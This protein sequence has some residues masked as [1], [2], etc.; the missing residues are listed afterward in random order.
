MNTLDEPLYR[1]WLL[2][3]N[4]SLVALVVHAELSMNWSGLKLQ[5]IEG[6][7]KAMAT[8]FNMRKRYR[9]K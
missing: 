5:N 3:R 9:W 6:L 4:A 1:A 2:S 8:T 7:P